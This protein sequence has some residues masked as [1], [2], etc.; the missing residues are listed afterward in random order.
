[1]SEIDEKLRITEEIQMECHRTVEGIM[2]NMVNNKE[3]S[4]QDATNVYFYKKLADFE[5]RLRQL[6]TSKP[7]NK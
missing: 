1:M 7:L 5:Y 2:N 4:V 6:E 3:I